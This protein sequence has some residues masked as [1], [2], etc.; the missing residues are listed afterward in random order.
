[1]WVSSMGQSSLTSGHQAPAIG[2]MSAE[3]PDM[4]EGISMDIPALEGIL[5]AEMSCLYQG[6]EMENSRASCE[7]R[8]YH[9][10]TSCF[11]N[12]EKRAVFSSPVTL[13]GVTSQ[14]RW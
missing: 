14:R 2:A 7:K 10:L 1:M 5:W 13:M 3:A 8:K 6:R 11:R 12:P 9:T 4:S